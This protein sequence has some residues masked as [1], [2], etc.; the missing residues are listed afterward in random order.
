MYKAPLGLN[1]AYV[2]PAR[3]GAKG[4]GIVWIHGGFEWGIDS[5]AWE[6]QSRDN[7]QSGAAFRRAGLAE[8]Y[9]ALRGASG[10]PGRPECFLGEVDDVLAAADYLAGRPDVDPQRVYLGGHSTGGV[11]ALL[12]AESTDRFRAIFSFGPVADPRQYGSNSCIPETA[13]NAEVRPRAPI[14]YLRE[15]TT[16]TWVIDGK[17][18]NAD[19]FPVM[20]KRAGRAPV[21]FVTIPEATH[22]NCLGPGTELIAK[23]IL[24]DT[25][26]KP[27]FAGITSDAIRTAMQSRW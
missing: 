20:Q 19:V 7:D 2:T 26:P 6:P 13:S 25:G 5:F 11:I 22:F 10:N 8:M 24:A 21:I 15:I 16:P 4:P 18:G 3:S 9:P 17:E 1:V 27:A 14:E 12:A 23:A